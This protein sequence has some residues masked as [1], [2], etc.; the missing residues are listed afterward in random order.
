MNILSAS[1]I[2]KTYNS[3]C[4]AL[5]ALSGVD[6][7]I[8]E[9]EFIGIMGASGS[10]K[11]T[12]L[13]LLSGIDKASS[14]SIEIKGKNIDKLSSDDLAL[15]RREKVGIVFQDFS[16]LDSLTIKENIILPMTLNKNNVNAVEKRA[17]EVL[18]LLDI[19]DIADKYP[20]QISG[21]QQQ[22]TAIGR[23]LIND[24]AIIFA[25][26]PTGNLDSKSSN[27]IMTYF[28]KIN[29]EKH[30]T[31]LMVTHDAFAASFC[32]RIIFI[33]DGCINSEII[34]NCNRKEFFDELLVHLSTI[35][36]NI[37]EV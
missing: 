22:R 31:V 17:R 23:A 2:T 21:G 5:T 28:E 3:D 30:C 7:C 25:D 24:P 14:G 29:K 32:H 10:G 26:E 13:N 9:G 33:K 15:F 18:K 4:L 12:L 8:E 27:S 35:G 6:L 16:L 36:G 11:S 1:N 37:S 34:K 19:F 20:F